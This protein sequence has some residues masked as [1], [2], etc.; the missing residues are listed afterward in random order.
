DGGYNSGDAL[1]SSVGGQ[2]R[3]AI[4]SVQEF[5][6]LTNQYDAEFG[7]ATGAVINAVTKQGT[8]QFRGVVF[9][10]FTNSKITA[11]DYFA[12]QPNLE[13]PNSNLN[14]WHDTFGGPI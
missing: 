6:V 9:G 3:T 5:Q 8:N 1:G 13:N 2:T 10:Y 12:R 4:E 7:R 11:A 14:Q